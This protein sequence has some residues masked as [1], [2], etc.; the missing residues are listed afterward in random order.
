MLRI[1]IRRGRNEVG[2]TLEGDL[3]GAWVA[4]LEDCWRSARSTLDGPC[5]VWICRRLTGSIG[6]AGTCS[7]FCVATERGLASGAAMTELVR[8]LSGDWPG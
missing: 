8:T 5:S 7:P 1:T 3:T 4:E 2:L 6:P